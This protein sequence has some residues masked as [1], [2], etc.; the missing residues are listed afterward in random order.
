MHNSALSLRPARSRRNLRRPRRREVCPPS[1]A[2]SRSV[3]DPYLAP[4]PRALGGCRLF[5][6]GSVGIAVGTTYTP[7]GFRCF[8]LPGRG[9]PG[10]GWRPREER[11]LS[12]GGS[13]PAQSLPRRRPGS[14]GWGIAG[15]PSI[16][17]SDE[18]AIPRR[19]PHSVSRS[20]SEGKCWKGRTSRR[21][22]SFFRGT[23]GSNPS[24]SSGQSVSRPHFLSWVENAGFPRACARLAW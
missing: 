1:A 12:R 4:I 8:R 2:G 17:C 23:E 21:G 7:G 13:G 5:G 15:T 20:L 19:P 10:G 11:P 6:L 22:G 16:R 9:R 24:S 3:L 14:F 18:V